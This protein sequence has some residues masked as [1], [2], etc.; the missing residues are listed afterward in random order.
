MAANEDIAALYPPPPPYYEFFTKENIEKAN[1]WIKEN[2]EALAKMQNSNK[3]EISE[4][5]GSEEEKQTNELE[6]PN[7]IRFLIPPKRPEG[8]SYRL[9]GD[10]W[11]F[12]DQMPTLKE[13]NVEQL[14]EDEL[15]DKD[16]DKT[17]GNEH[18]VKRIEELKKLFKSLL[19]NFLEL[20]G[21]VS[22]NPELKH[23][24]LQEIRVILTN[25]HHLL[26]EYRPH[27]ARES[28][29]LMLQ[30]QVNLAK[31]DIQKIKKG[32]EEVR[33]ILP[34]LAKESKVEEKGMDEE[35]F[36]QPVDE[37]QRL[38]E[39]GLHLLN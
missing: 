35:G 2:E 37:I 15:E 7:D 5:K 36:V 26:N 3:Q 23:T 11:L 39:E 10:M 34:K 12:K 24:K 21:V 38:K 29:I 33:A 20:I 13:M 32:C 14:Y 17:E 9:F 1:Q 6:I 22:K 27:Q 8:P 31:N 4:E 16:S 25:I 18:S 28:L 19:L 30:N